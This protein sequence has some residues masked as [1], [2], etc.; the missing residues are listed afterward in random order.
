MNEHPDDLKPENIDGDINVYVVEY[1][2]D[3]EL[4]SHVDGEPARETQ[5]AGCFTT[6]DAA[7]RFCTENALYGGGQHYPNWHW[8]ICRRKLNEHVCNVLNPTE[9]YWHFTPDGIECDVSG[10]PLKVGMSDKTRCEIDELEHEISDI[11]R[12]IEKIKQHCGVF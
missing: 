5:V 1:W 12:D 8:C 3:E 10:Y 7:W 2:T 11:K 6:F 4:L 9:V